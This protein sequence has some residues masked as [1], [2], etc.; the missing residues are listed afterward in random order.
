ME[1]IEDAKKIAGEC[2]F[3]TVAD[4]DVDKIAVRKEARDACA[5]NKCHQYGINWSCPPGCGTLDECAERLRAFKRGLIL[6]TT[7]ELEDPLDFDG[8][9][10]A[11]QRHGKSF[12]AFGEQVRRIY[13]SSMLIGSGGCARC[14]EC[15]YPDKPCRFP[16]KVTSSM[17]ALGMIVSDVCRDNDVKYY[18]G[19]GTLTYVSCVLLD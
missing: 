12:E 2:G 16:D 19:P 1:K 3:T 6:Q 13:P 14:K 15:T 8:M 17:E 18:Y 10:E 4:L 11:A 9:M 7:A 5:E